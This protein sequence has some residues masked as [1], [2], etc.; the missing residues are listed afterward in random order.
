MSSH[1][2]ISRARLNDAVM[3]ALLAL[4]F[5]V[6]FIL[7]GNRPLVWI[8]AA[9][10]LSLLSL[11][12]FAFLAVLDVPTAMPLRR[13]PFLVIA[14][15]IFVAY[16]IFQVLPIAHFLP[17]SFLFLPRELEP[18]STI[19]VSSGDTFMAMVCWYSIIVLFYLVLE[20]TANRT[21]AKRFLTA[22]F[23]IVVLHAIYGFFLFYEMDDMILF[24]EK[25]AYKG[26]MT[27]GFVNR[28]TFGTFLASGSVLGI[29]LIVV[30]YLN[31]SMKRKSKQF[32]IDPRL[33][34]TFVGWLIVFTALARTNSR[35]GLFV[36][37]LGVAIISA[38]FVLNSTSKGFNRLFRI[39]AVAIGLS[40][41]LM[42]IIGFYGLLTVERLGSTESDYDVRAQ[43]YEQVW[44]MILHRPF[45]GYGGGTFETSYPL[46][47]EL[48]VSVDLV[49]DKT[50]N[51]YLALLVDYGL[52][53]GSL[54]ILAVL[55]IF[56]K[57]FTKLWTSEK[58]DLSLISAFAVVLVA[59]V[60]ALFDFSLEIQGYAFLFVAIIATGFSRACSEPK[61]VRK[62]PL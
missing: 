7:G 6:P 61:E 15:V 43:L 16:L 26:S 51:T 1:F 47:H 54:P 45:T 58:P 60:H 39:S 34:I 55:F 52:V 17:K 22:L 44:Q 21:R 24:V 36:G 23:G 2:N 13:M 62:A 29:A 5:I 59:A 4:I 38:Y 25:W 37:I 32:S 3:W 56:L 57:I 28:N 50:H 11:V 19:T 49:W 53:F 30:N 31:N 46:F 10:V 9:L 27:G 8:L 33:F 35:M 14:M 20:C 18:S 48:P 12:N 40:F 42:A 41:F